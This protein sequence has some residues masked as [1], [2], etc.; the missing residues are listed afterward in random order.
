MTET[1]RIAKIEMAI[2]MRL[3]SFSL[4]PEHKRVMRITSKQKE[5]KDER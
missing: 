4:V 1:G 3:F 5:K 2:W